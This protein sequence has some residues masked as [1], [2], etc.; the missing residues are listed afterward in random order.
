MINVTG[1]FV[2]FINSKGTLELLNVENLEREELVSNNVFVSMNISNYTE[3]G[4]VKNFL[5]YLPSVFE[6]N[7][8]AFKFWVKCQI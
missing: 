8:I 6:L 7:K 2:S 5:L 1:S 4:L 3:L